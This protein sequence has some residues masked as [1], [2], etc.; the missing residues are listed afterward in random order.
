MARYTYETLRVWWVTT[1]GSLTAPSAA[2]VNAGNDLTTFVPVDGINLGGSRNNA[3]QAMLGDA[4]VAEEPGTWGTTMEITFT[5]DSTEGATSPWQVFAGGYKSV[6]FLVLRRVGTG[7][8]V[9]T[10]K[11]EVY[12]ATSHEP[13]MLASAENEYSKFTVVF[14]ITAK[15]ELEAVAA[16]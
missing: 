5:R 9:A 16:A 8:L 14:A 13:Q 10:Q 4:F 11:V 12:P 6:G 15:P 1:L 3:S 2:Q 7:V